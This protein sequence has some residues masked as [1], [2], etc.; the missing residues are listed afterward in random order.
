MVHHL[1]QYTASPGFESKCFT[2]KLTLSSQEPRW[3]VLLWTW[4]AGCDSDRLSDLPSASE[5]RNLNKGRLIPKPIHRTNYSIPRLSTLSGISRLH[6]SCLLPSRLPELPVQSSCTFSPAP[7]S[8]ISP[9]IIT[10]PQ[11]IFPGLHSCLLLWASLGVD[12]QKIYL[13]YIDDLP[14]VWPLVF[15]LL[16]SGWGAFTHFYAALSTAGTQAR[17]SSHSMERSFIPSLFQLCGAALR[18]YAQADMQGLGNAFIVT[19]PRSH[20]KC[21]TRLQLCYDTV[22]CLGNGWQC[23]PSRLHFSFNVCLN[24]C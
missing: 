18:I 2:H 13:T 22:C 24:A 14:R 19:L 23:I 8:E 6:L 21:E 20:R 11:L 7:H 15:G 1:C 12:F 16:T 3:Q 5:S 9:V 17:V 4:K 10:S